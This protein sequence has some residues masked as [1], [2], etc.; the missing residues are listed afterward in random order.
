M[1]EDLIEAQRYAEVVEQLRRLNTGVEALHMQGDRQLSEM[2]NVA[3]KVEAALRYFVKAWQ[4]LKGR[5][6]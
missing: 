2:R 6:P 4:E 3:A 5:K 1:N